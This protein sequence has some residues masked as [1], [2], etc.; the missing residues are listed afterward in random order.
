[1]TTT[2]VPERFPE[3]DIARGIAVIM[4]VVF[5]I[6]FDLWFL[7]IMPV[8]AGSPPWRILALMT[9]GLFLFL[10]G[11]SLSISAEYARKKLA[12]NEFIKKYGIR[13]AGI[14]AIGMGITLVTWI[15]LPGAFIIFGILHLIGLAVALSPLYTGYSWQN[16]VAGVV[17]ILLGPI[18]TLMRG[19]G[20][21][22]WFGI[23]PPAFY[24]IDYTPVVP[25]LGVVLLGVYAGT[26]AYPAGVRRRNIVFPEVL[27][28]TL[29]FLGRHSLAMYL[30]HQPVIL[31]ILFV[32]FPGVF[33]SFAPPGLL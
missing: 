16:L 27:G 29:G 9:A 11:V 20:W 12:R 15:I 25:W 10:V 32:F 21:L 19:T 22:V 8:P 14:F 6:A 33:Y 4:M 1:M 24:S 5:H 3:I 18:V 28:K 31:G 30:I 17:I 2:H 26:L 23:H 7:G 13:G